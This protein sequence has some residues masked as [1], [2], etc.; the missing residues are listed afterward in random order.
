MQVLYILVLT[1]SKLAIIV[2]LGRVFRTTNFDSI[3]K[4]LYVM[5]IAKGIAFAVVDI[6]QCSPIA[7]A[8][9][10][11]VSRTCVD[12]HAV[13]IAGSAVSIADDIVLL[14]LPLPWIWSLQLKATTRVGLIVIFGLG[15]LYVAPGISLFAIPTTAR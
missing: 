8:W 12:I 6:F 2:F 9:D 7:G 15:S 10:F 4:W 14:V 11:S 1:L 3:A 13:G 5:I